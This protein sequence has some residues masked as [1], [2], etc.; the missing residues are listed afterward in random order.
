MNTEHISAVLANI[1]SNLANNTEMLTL[2]SNQPNSGQPIVA[3][4]VTSQQSDV[5]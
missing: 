4:S 3:T 5:L 2:V 1:N